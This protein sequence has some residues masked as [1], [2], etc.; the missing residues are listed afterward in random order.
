[1]E[2]GKDMVFKKYVCLCVL[3]FV[4]LIE[5]EEK[6]DKPKGVMH[7]Y[8]EDEKE[9]KIIVGVFVGLH[10]KQDFFVETLLD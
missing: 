3:Q 1:M 9:K 2:K 10:C 7:T 5:N 6:K 8:I 4:I